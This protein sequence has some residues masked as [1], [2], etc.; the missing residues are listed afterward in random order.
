MPLSK[1]GS[2]NAFFIA[3][4][5]GN[6]GG[7]STVA[8]PSNPQNFYAILDGS[9]DETIDGSY[10]DFTQTTSANSAVKPIEL[11]ALDK[12]IDD[13]VANTGNVIS[14]MIATTKYAG[15]QAYNGTALCSSGANYLIGS[16]HTN[17]ECT[18]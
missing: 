8:D 1:L 6:G 7:Y 14:G 17:F 13:G 9:Q 12:K 11:L 3:S 10:W 15:I 18:R 4:A 2:A 16:R 5:I